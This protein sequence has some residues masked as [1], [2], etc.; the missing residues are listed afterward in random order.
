M[1]QKILV[2]DAKAKLQSLIKKLDAFDENKEFVVE[3]D[4]NC[5]GSYLGGDIDKW[6][7]WLSNNNREVFLYIE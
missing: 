6:E 2:K 5:G 4:D 3:I 1:E 7:T